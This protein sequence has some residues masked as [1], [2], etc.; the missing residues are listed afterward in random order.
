MQE[1]IQLENCDPSNKFL[2][3]DCEYCVILNG[4]R[5]CEWDIFEPCN[6]KKS[7]LYTPVEFDCNYFVKR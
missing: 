6:L 5:E 4:N 7:E 2:C 1:F 3:R